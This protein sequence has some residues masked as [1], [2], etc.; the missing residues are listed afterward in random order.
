MT[1]EEL[2]TNI[3]SSKLDDSALVF[4]YTDNMYLAKEYLNKISQIKKLKLYEVEDFSAFLSSQ[5]NII[6][7]DNSDYLYFYITD[8]F[9]V[10]DSTIEN[11]KNII[12]ICK[13]TSVKNS[14]TFP[15]L[16]DW[17]IKDYIKVNC[18]G[19]DESTI[20]LLYNL[21]NGDIYRIKNEIDK[22]KLFDANDQMNILYKFIAD[23]E[24]ADTITT[25][26][27]NL[28]NAILKKDRSKLLAVLPALNFSEIKP[29]AIVTLLI[30]NFKNLIDVQSSS[31]SPKTLNMSEKQFKAIQYNSK[32]YGKHEIINKY[33]FLLNFDYNIKNGYLDIPENY[34]IDYIICNIV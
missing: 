32:L 27:F 6:F 17:M 29:Y 4:K 5:K 22:L 31:A 16:E 11:L 2:K 3:L 18:C 33:Q 25:D 15:K 7:N 13:N 10:E 28:T 20:D 9:T 23:N 34:I 14:V 24:F 12:I 8:N 30:K 26:I 21:S 1:L 19:L